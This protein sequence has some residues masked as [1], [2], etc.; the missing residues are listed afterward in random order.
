MRKMIALKVKDALF[1]CLIGAVLYAGFKDV[2]S[3]LAKEKTDDG[4]DRSYSTPVSQEPVEQKGL[5]PE[6]FAEMDTVK[7]LNT[8]RVENRFAGIAYYDKATNMVCHVVTDATLLNP[9]AINC[10]PYKES[11]K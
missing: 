5:T 10:T 1:M 9:K 4:W 6:E 3:A 11:K 7:I 8:Y 2:T